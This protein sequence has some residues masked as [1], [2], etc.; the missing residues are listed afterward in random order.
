MATYGPN[1]AGTGTDAGSSWTT[2]GNITVND[3][4][5]AIWSTNDG[6]GGCFLANTRIS[7]PYGEKF[8]QDLLIGDYVYDI[9]MNIVEVQEVHKILADSYLMI[10]TNEETVYVTKEHPFLYKT[11]FLPIHAIGLGEV[12]SDMVIINKTEILGPVDVYNLSVNGSNTFIANN[13]KVHN[14]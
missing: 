10:T 8:I 3:S 6:G 13:F 11:N 2:P 9:N 4:S 5:F 12:I 1:T 14:K 7:T